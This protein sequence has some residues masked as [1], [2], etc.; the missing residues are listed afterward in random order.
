M[1]QQH[2]LTLLPLEPLSPEPA[3]IDLEY[4]QDFINLA[5]DLQGE[6]NRSILGSEE[7]KNVDIIPINYLSLYEQA[8]PLWGQSRDLFL[9]IY[10]TI[11][12]TAING[13][14]GLKS[15][16]GLLYFLIAEMWDDFYPKLD[17]D[18]DNDP[19]QRINAFANISPLSESSDDVLH[20][21]AI[22][23]KIQ[24]V[25]TLRYT[26]HD[27][28]CYRKVII[29]EDF[30]G[31]SFY[32]EMLN[33]EPAILIDAYQEVNECVALVDS[34]IDT[35][36]SKMAGTGI[37]TMDDLKRRLRMLQTFFTEII[38]AEGNVIVDSFANLEI[39]T[40]GSQNQD[41]IVFP[42]KALHSESNGGTR[43]S[44]ERTEELNLSQLKISN[45]RDALLVI[46]KAIDY[47]KFNEPTSPAPYLLQRTLKLAEMNFIDLINEIDEGAT[48]RAKDQF[49]IRDKS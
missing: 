11:I 1:Y 6:S 19:T 35:A 31:S 22:F 43:E 27:L 4:N 18:D 10:I 39:K 20:F 25:P 44:N 14:R 7:D 41:G 32:N 37:L 33:Q 29:V 48:A 23:T 16:L 28:M 8:V 38:P 2:Q 9:A 46:N 34:I 21:V 47:F 13:T 36:N 40:N 3:G 42:E 45:R 49:G 26:V 17:P 30:D 12:M 5:Q 15:G 24:L